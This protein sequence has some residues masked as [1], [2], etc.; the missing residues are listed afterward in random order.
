VKVQCGSCKSFIAESLN[1]CPS[2]QTIF[3][4]DKVITN[5]GNLDQQ[6]KNTW[7]EKWL[8]PSSESFNKRIETE[9][10]EAD[11]IKTKEADRIKKL[12]R[13]ETIKTIK[14][15]VYVAFIVVILLSLIFG[16]INALMI[17]GGIAFLII[18]AIIMD[19]GSSG[20]PAK[21]SGYYNQNL[22]QTPRAQISGYSQT[23]QAQISGYY[24]CTCGNMHHSAYYGGSQNCSRCGRPMTWRS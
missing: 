9:T 11:R 19:G 13:E 24:Q 16:I 12:E 14:T 7:D 17:V 1:Q 2:C 10:K 8:N 5:T 4:K 23:P 6:G 18:F 21:H 20:A 15:T 3:K 22:Q